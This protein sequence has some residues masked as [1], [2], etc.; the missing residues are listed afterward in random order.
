MISL[1]SAAFSDNSAGRESEE[2]FFR[3]KGACTGRALPDETAFR[4]GIGV[5]CR[6]RM[7]A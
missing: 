6:V 4:S 3:P 2:M 7:A 5:P 1:P